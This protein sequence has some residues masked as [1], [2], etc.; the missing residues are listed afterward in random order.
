MT[1]YDV[2]LQY[3]AVKA[4]FHSKKYDYFRFNGKMG[5]RVNLDTY[6]RRSDIIFFQRLARYRDPLMML[7]YNLVESEHWIGEICLNEEARA[8]YAKHKKVNQ[9][10]KYHLE[11]E[12][13]QYDSIKELIEVKGSHPLVIKDYLKE[14]ISLE[15]LT[16]LCDIA[17][18]F[19]YWKRELPQDLLMDQIIHRVSRYKGF[20]NYERPVVKNIV[21]R[22]LNVS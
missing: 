11:Q 10:L 22:S 9:A 12:L 14:K 6:E 1:G 13:R 5:P 3:A 16:V 20:M 4:H 21:C 17:R 19:S 8:M 2:Y 7:V 18:P 15:T